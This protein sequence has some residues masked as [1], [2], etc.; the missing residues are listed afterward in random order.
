MSLRTLIATS[1]MSVLWIG[2]SG[3]A[4]GQHGSVDAPKLVSRTSPAYPPIAK[5]AHISGDVRLQLQIGAD[6]HVIDSKALSGPPM[7]QGAAKEC[8]KDWVYEPVLHNGKSQPASTVV[9]VSF[10]LPAPINP[11]DEKIAAEFFP[12]DQECVKAV[13]SRADSAQQARLCSRAAEIA[14]K[15]STQER[16]IERRSAFVYAATALRRNH[17]MKE[18]LSFADKAVAV[19]AQ[20]HDD[21][22]GS[23][24]AYSTRAQVLAEMGDLSHASEDLTKAE[25]FEREA[26]TK[27]MPLDEA[28]TKH[29]YV[30]ELK[31]MLN[32][33]AQ[34]LRAKG[35]SAEADAKVAEAAKL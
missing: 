20:G 21:G 1:L 27:M 8:V 24:A 12:I 22:S 17:Q 29:Q 5:A 35:E 32:F 33:H 3:N 7:L 34:I 23:S 31:A 28:F 15:F 16:F 13:S 30:P 10:T 9:T 18:S 26:I 25:E 4:L 14:E 6:G 11:N 2:H 19:V